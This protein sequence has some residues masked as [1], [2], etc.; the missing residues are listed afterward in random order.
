M[1]SLR[2]PIKVPALGLEGQITPNRQSVRGFPG[3]IGEVS[4]ELGCYARS[5]HQCQGE[6]PGYKKDIVRLGVAA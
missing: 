1:A 6:E 2:S 4:V 3:Q 5:S